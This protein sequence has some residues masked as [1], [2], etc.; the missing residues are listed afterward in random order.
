MTDNNQLP[1]SGQPTIFPSRV[2]WRAV[3][4][5]VIVACG[6][7]WAV[8]LPLW[9][10]GGLANPIAGLL[11][12]VMMFTPTIAMLVV[13]LV[14]R[15]PAQHR[16]RFL[17]MWPLRPAGR[18][19][20]FLALGLFGPWILSLVIAGVSALCGWAIIDPENSVVAQQL[21][22]ALPGEIDRELITTVIIVQIV[23][24]PLNAILSS[25]L[26]VGEELGWRGWLTPALRPLGTGATLLLTGVIWGLWHSPIILLGYNFARPDL[27]GVLLMVVGCVA[28][29]V[30]LGW[31]RLRTASV[32]PAVL[33]HGSLNASAAVFLALFDAQKLDLALA[34]PLGVAA[35]IVL[36][37]VIAILLLTGQFR[38]QPAP[39]LP[40]AW[41]PAPVSLP[42]PPQASSG[43][44]VD[45]G[46][47]GSDT[48]GRAG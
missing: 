24:T 30:L 46:G 6:L 12:P 2:P 35:W 15:S 20:L 39:L 16:L 42:A 38:R 4:V 44:V 9:L 48:D 45:M 31:L 13:V 33:A 47:N 32:W 37:V 36:A 14:L 25:M 1:A 3:I 8:T 19:I 27:S 23:A 28:W 7:A 26:A 29:G 5:F 18:T 41:G 34:G 21:A 40:A 22:A 10:N 17:G 11:L 43:H